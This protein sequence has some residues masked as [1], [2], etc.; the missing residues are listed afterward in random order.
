MRAVNY[1]HYSVYKFLLVN[2]RSCF[3]KPDAVE[4][5][6]GFGHIVGC[7]AE[8]GFECPARFACRRRQVED[9]GRFKKI[10]DFGQASA[11][12]DRRTSIILPALKTAVNQLPPA[13]TPN[14]Q[15][16][17]AS[18]VDKPMHINRIECAELPCLCTAVFLSS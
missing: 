5:K 15:T 10:S 2:L 1:Y 18:A 3:A 17:I 9:R 8:P 16:K 4:K 14:E 13:S 12:D 11:H 7:D 6:A